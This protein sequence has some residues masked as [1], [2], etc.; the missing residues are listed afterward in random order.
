MTEETENFEPPEED[1]DEASYHFYNTDHDVSSDARDNVGPVD[2]TTDVAD[3]EEANE[4]F[5]NCNTSTVIPG[6]VA[7]IT[8]QQTCPTKA[9]NN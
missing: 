6:Q 2:S 1:Y 8:T 3:T 7:T 4:H 9:L 5:Y